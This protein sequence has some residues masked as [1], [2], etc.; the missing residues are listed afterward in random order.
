MILGL[1]LLCPKCPQ[2]LSWIPGATVSTAI[3]SPSWDSFFIS[4]A[5]RKSLIPPQPCVTHVGWCISLHRATYILGEKRFAW[6]NEFAVRNSRQCQWRE[7]TLC[8][9]LSGSPGAHRVRG[10]LVAPSKPRPPGRRRAPGRALPLA[11][12]SGSSC[13]KRLCF[14]SA[15]STLSCIPALAVLPPA[16][17]RSSGPSVNQTRHGLQHARPPCPSPTPGVYSN[18][19][20][21]SWWCHPAISSSVVPFSSHLQSFP[22]SGSFPKSGND[23]LCIRWP[24]Y[25]HFSISLIIFLSEWVLLCEYTLTLDNEYLWNQAMFF[26]LAFVLNTF[27]NVYV[28]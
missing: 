20:P 8:S 13:V 27:D 19:C 1:H 22:A 7:G 11:A 9:W 5:F 14:F 23:H 15:P 2:E 3:I 10:A 6:R 28:S 21:L 24:K 4:G 17:R 16:A 18:S 25:W 12:P 26:H